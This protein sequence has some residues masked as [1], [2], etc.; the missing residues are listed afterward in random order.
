M[1][2]SG[3]CQGL[4]P[5]SSLPEEV[6]TLLPAGL[7]PPILLASASMAPPQRSF[8]S[9]PRPC[10]FSSSVDLFTSTVSTSSVY[11]FV[12]LLGLCEGALSPIPLSR[13]NGNSSRAGTKSV[14]LFLNPQCSTLKELLTKCERERAGEE[15][16]PNGAT[17]PGGPVSCGRRQYVLLSPSIM[18]QVKN[19]TPTWNEKPLKRIGER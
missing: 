2:C 16:P 19:K 13:Q 12:A 6:S 5:R 3:P 9:P 14:L 10:P 1:P 7:V 17:V 15:V 8:P 18:V 11:S 4:T